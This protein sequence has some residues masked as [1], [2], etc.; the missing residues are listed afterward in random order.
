MFSFDDDCSVTWHSKR[1]K[2]ER[3]LID[4]MGIVCQLHDSNCISIWDGLRCAELRAMPKWHNGE[5]K[6]CET[7]VGYLFPSTSF[8]R[9][10]CRVISKHTNRWI[11]G[12]TLHK[13]SVCEA[14]RY[15]AAESRGSHTMNLIEKH[16]QPI[17]AHHW[18]AIS[19]QAFILKSAWVSFWMK[20]LL[21]GSERRKTAKMLISP[22]EIIIART[23]RWT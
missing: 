16:V 18:N 12:M 4:E 10:L 3:A 13:E 19:Y 20:T 21:Q 15:F 14:I 9:R 8:R 11:S 7:G 5:W 1:R 6:S 23:K 17:R 22:T 2:R